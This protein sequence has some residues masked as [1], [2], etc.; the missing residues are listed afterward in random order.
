M[1]ILTFQISHWRTNLWWR[2]NKSYFNHYGKIQPVNT[3]YDI[4]GMRRFWRTAYANKH[5]CTLFVQFFLFPPKDSKNIH[6]QSTQIKKKNLISHHSLF[7]AW[8]TSRKE[9]ALVGITCVIHGR[10][11]MELLWFIC[12]TTVNS[13][14]AIY[15]SA[16]RRD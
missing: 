4:C 16:L 12:K 2:L 10:I 5:I 8:K 13:I 6:Y 1:V 11:T 3:W 14:F 15:G 9:A 7:L